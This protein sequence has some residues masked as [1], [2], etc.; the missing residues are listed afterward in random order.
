MECLYYPKLDF[1]NDVIKINQEELNHLKALRLRINENIYISNGL[2]LIVVAKLID[3]HSETA[4]LKIVDKLPNKGELDHRLGL[5]IGILSDRNR[6]EIALEKAVELGCTDFYPII[7][8]YCEKTKLNFD[9]LER[10]AIAAMKQSIRSKLINIH[11]QN[12]LK[13]LKE[14][15]QNFKQVILADENSQKISEKFDKVDTLVIIGPEGGFDQEEIEFMEREIQL[16]KI[17]LANRR[18]RA[19]TAAVA[20]LSLITNL[21]NNHDRSLLV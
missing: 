19:E 16:R 12:H 4:I 3:I 17:K 6:F 13:D 11:R 10:K 14:I 7:T 9:R 8:K 20:S 18:L 15:T 1:Q 21:I 5:A 2:G